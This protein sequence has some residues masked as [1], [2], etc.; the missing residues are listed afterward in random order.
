MTWQ[1]FTHAKTIGLSTTHSP[2]RKQKPYR[3]PNKIFSVSSNR[4]PT[5]PYRRFDWHDY[6]KEVENEYKAARLAVD[7]LKAALVENP[8]LLTPGGPGR[9]SVRDADNN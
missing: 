9:A 2:V 3:S 8:S 1:A 6:I 4:F 5:M 7:R